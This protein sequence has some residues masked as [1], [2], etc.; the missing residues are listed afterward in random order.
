MKKIIAVVIVLSSMLFFGCNKPKEEKLVLGFVPLMDADKLIENV[1]PLAEILSEAIGI[2]VEAF[3]ANN[4]VGV[5]EAI[6][7]GQVDFGIIPPFAYV[8][9]KNNFDAE[10]ILS[11]LNK[12]G[13]SFYRSEFIVKKGSP[14][15]TVEDIR[16]KKVA[17]VDPSS[18]S[19][20]IFP[21]AYLKKHGIDLDRDITSVFSG[22]HDKSLQL[23]MT[24]SVDVVAVFE[25]ARNR[26]K[27]DFNTIFETTETLVFTDNIPYISVTVRHDLPNDVKEK[28]RSGILKSLNHGTGK[29]IMIELFSL[30]GFVEADDS[31]YQGIRDAAELMDID[32]E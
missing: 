4:Y 9:A 14:I 24:G 22:G 5:I 3:T 30:H 27:K 16:N 32:L 8:L 20:Y 7:A 15:H 13:K 1:E 23:L 10:V 29:E 12:S 11:A 18:S 21:G 28:I 31:D 17:F 26:Y 6:G 19:G 2:K 25:G